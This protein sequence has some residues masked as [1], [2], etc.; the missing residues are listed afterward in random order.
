MTYPK[1]KPCPK[2]KAEVAC[3]TYESGWSRVECDNCDS[4][5]SCEGR[6]LD[7]IRAHN[8]AASIG[9][10]SDIPGP[11]LPYG[12]EHGRKEEGK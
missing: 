10:L 2:C 12:Y 4:I 3:Y 7:A 9:S 11:E 6:K 8:A 5:H 1:M